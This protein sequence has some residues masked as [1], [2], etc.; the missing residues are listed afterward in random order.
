M[1]AIHSALRLAFPFRDVAWRFAGIIRAEAKFLPA[2][3]RARR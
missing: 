3:G 2:A 1:T